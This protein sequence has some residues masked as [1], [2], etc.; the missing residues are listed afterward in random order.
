MTFNSQNLIQ[1]VF[2]SLAEKF[3]AEFLHIVE[4]ER[5]R[6]R[7]R[8][9]LLSSLFVWA[10]LTSP[11]FSVRASFMSPVVKLYNSI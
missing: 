7:E 9:S 4:R 5:E 1:N 6:E 2:F 10:S 3:N 8:G 11:V